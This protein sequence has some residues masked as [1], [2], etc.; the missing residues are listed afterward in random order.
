MSSSDCV[1]RSMRPKIGDILY[2]AVWAYGSKDE[3]FFIEYT[4]ERLTT[5]GMWLVC[6]EERIVS[7]SRTWRT[8]T[9]HFAWPTKEQAVGSLGHRGYNHI[10]RL[11]GELDLA[12]QRLRSLSPNGPIPGLHTLK[13]TLDN[14]HTTASPQGNDSWLNG[15]NPEDPA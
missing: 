10:C 5:E 7:K 4:V 3:Y 15:W 2:R 1:E 14:K 13:H 12:L 8:F 9:T 11:A 6:P